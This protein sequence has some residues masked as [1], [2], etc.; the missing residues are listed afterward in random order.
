MAKETETGLPENQPQRSSSLILAK[1][2]NVRVSI[3][4]WL[5]N[6]GKEKL[7]ESDHQQA[8]QAL[9]QLLD[10]MHLDIK[11]RSQVMDVAS[12]SRVTTDFTRSLGVLG[13]LNES[14]QK[15]CGNDN[16]LKA[17]LAGEF[18]KGGHFI[19]QDNGEF[20]R[21]VAAL[22]GA[23]LRYSSHFASTRLVEKGISCGRIIPEMLV[24]HTKDKEGIE[25][26]HF[27]AEAS[28]WRGF[29]AMMTSMD[30]LQTA[31]HITDS[32]WYLLNKIASTMQG[33]PVMNLGPYGWSKHDDAHAIIDMK[34]QPPQVENA[35]KVI[36]QSRTAPSMADVFDETPAP[37]AIAAKSAPTEEQTSTIKLRT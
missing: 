17:T 16:V 20:F 37:K 19:L 1:L 31:E 5:R 14:L 22:E 6:I 18:F 35:A 2:G 12:Q 8:M 36:A 33:T 9:G 28:P 4:D 30:G 10:Q 23:E 7:S 21:R 32:T 27:Q 26:S 24:I 11:L 34:V 29:G 3:V 15:E 13:L 25:R